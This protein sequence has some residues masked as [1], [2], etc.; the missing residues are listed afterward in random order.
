LPI[1][2]R[3]FLVCSAWAQSDGLKSRVRP[4]SGKCSLGT[5]EAQCFVMFIHNAK[6]EY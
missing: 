5:K 6:G 3:S 2:Q 1:V 4:S